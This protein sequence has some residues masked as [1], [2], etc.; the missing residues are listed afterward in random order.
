MACNRSAIFTL[1]GGAFDQLGRQVRLRALDCVA[2]GVRPPP[3]EIGGAVAID[4]CSR[5]PTIAGASRISRPSSDRSY[6][7]CWSCINRGFHAAS[8]RIG[9]RRPRGGEAYSPG[10]RRVRPACRH[11]AKGRRD[12][13]RGFAPPD[14]FQRTWIAARSSF[15]TPPTA[16]VWR[17][18]E[19]RL[20]Y[21]ASRIDVGRRLAERLYNQPLQFT[22]RQ[23]HNCG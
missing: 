20:E 3:V 12:L 8:V 16:A 11:G 23:H 6:R 5:S 22:H 9:Q 17:E 13:T 7:R 4:L 2:K 18:A 21:R 19:R 14:G 1:L 10:R 15:D